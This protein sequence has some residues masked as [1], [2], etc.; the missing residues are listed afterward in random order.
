MNLVINARDALAPGGRIT[1][2]TY[3]ANVSELDAARHPHAGSGPH[4]VL[5]VADTGHGMDKETQAHIFE[6]FFTTKRGSGGS[7]L[8]LATSYGI[9]RQA[10]GHIRLL[11]APGR[12]TTFSVYL[13]ASAERETP[14][15]VAAL[16]TAGRGRETL[17]IVEDS[18]VIL[19]LAE[20]TLRRQ[21]YTVLTA[22]DGQSA[23]EKVEASNLDFDLLMTDIVMP[24]LSGYDLAKRLA[25]SRPRLKV[26]YVSGYADSTYVNADFL[27][28]RPEFLKKP[29]TPS[30]LALKVRE[31]L[32]SNKTFH[33]SKPA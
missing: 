28:S 10:R 17:L 2:R 23:L 24:R 29:F 19:R 32:D 5:E 26:L 25:S 33:L 30:A 9:V 15:A 20:E 11:S 14:T 1:L 3:A 18:A 16:P 31:V 6:P 21:G 22:P 7:G 8:G 12:G 13:P 27:R 4:V